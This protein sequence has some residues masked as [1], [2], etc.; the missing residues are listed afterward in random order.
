[1]AKNGEVPQKKM[2]GG[3][4]PSKGGMKESKLPGVTTANMNFKP[5]QN[6]VDRGSK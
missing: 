3:N 6:P 5:G 1:M 4:Y 2:T